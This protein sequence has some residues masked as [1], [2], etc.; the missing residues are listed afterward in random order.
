MDLK[1]YFI[2]ATL[3]IGIPVY[4]VQVNGEL[5][6]PQFTPGV[7]LPVTA[8]Q[9]CVPGYATRVRNVSE[10]EKN[11]VYKEYGI[12]PDGSRF[13]VDH[14]RALTIGGSNDIKNLWPQPY[15]GQYNAHD[16]DRLEQRLHYLVCHGKLPLEQAQQDISS[17]WIEAY[18]KYLGDKK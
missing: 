17:N 12:K 6:I 13:E 10:A 2:L 16:K 3:M 9:V 5:P 4:A 11:A 14:L 15:Q 18:R 7:S 8:K 1:Q